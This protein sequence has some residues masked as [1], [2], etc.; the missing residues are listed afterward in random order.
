MK[1]PMKRLFCMLLA[2]LMTVSII[3]VAP[4]GAETAEAATLSELQD[5]AA[6]SKARLAELKKQLSEL[7]SSKADALAQKNVLDE[8][9]NL[10][11]SQIDNASAQITAL[12]SELAENQKKEEAQYELFCEQVR[13]EEERGTLSYWSV[14][15]KASSFT[16]LL[17]RIDF[18]NEVAEHDKSVIATLQDLRAH[19]QSDKD[20]L[21]SQKSELETRQAELTEQRA[22][23]DKLYEQL[24][25]DASQ[26]QKMAAAEEASADRIEQEIK[27]RQ[28]TPS[29][30]AT[31]GDYIWPCSA[32]YITSPFGRRTSPGG[33]G[34]TNHKGVDIG[35]SYGSSIYATKAGTVIVSSYDAGGYGNYVQIDHGGGNYTL[36]GHMSKRLVSVGQTV[37]Q[38]EVIGLCGSTGASTGPHVHYEIWVNR[39]RIDPLPYLPGYIRYW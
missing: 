19:I 24:S 4:G 11:Q 22:E 2:A 25:A 39:T 21:E 12:E 34:S 37:S 6:A 27:N 14:L 3:A 13:S 29:T 17:S 7:Q 18:V 31:S 20:N 9:N 5:Q 8:Q 1:K 23:A 33:I 16:D 32:R 30:P 10:L 36:Y 15:F 38:G 26:M 35:A 28:E